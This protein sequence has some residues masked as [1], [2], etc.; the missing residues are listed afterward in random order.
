MGMGAGGLRR[1]MDGWSDDALGKAYDHTVVVRLAKYVRPYKWRVVIA[2]IGTILFSLT[3]YTQPYLIGQATDY[4]LA[5]NM[6]DLV[7]VSLGLVGLA[8]LAWVSYYGYM[9]TTAWMGH[10][11]LLTLREEMFSHLQKLSLSFYDRNEVG[12]VMSR[13]QNDVTSLQELLTSGFFTILADFLGLAVILFWLFKL[14]WVL[15]LGT[16]SVL[17]FL[18]IVLWI[19][20]ERAKKAF[21]RVRQAI[22]VVNSNLQENI[23]GVRV[24]Q[25]LNRESENQRRFDSVNADNLNA[26]VDAARLTAIVNPAVEISV[27]VAMAVVIILGGIRV[28]NGLTTVGVIVSFALYVQR[29]FDPVREL[30]MQYAQLQRAMAGGQRAFEVLD[31]QPEIED[32]PDALPIPPIKGDVTFEDVRFSYI[33]GIPVLRNINL[34]VSPGQNIALVGQTGSGKTTITAL[35]ARLYDVTSGSVRIDGIDVRDVQR[36]SINRQMGVV[37]QDPFLFSGTV[38]DNLRYGRPEATDEEIIEGSRAVG[39][40]EFI[41]QF[42]NGYDTVLVERGQN[43]SL[44][45][46]QLL[47]FARAIIANPRILV[48]DEATAKVDSTTEVSIQRA[49]K[50]L[51]KGRTSFV[52]AHRLSTIRGADRIIVLQSGKIVEDGTHEELVA[53]NG[54]YSSLY[55]M[56]Y[57]SEKAAG[58]GENGTIIAS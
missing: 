48:L 33:P 7:L 5:G 15:A 54:V 45:Q 29:F 43:I 14:D 3:S 53:R 21:I 16:I 19:W 36:I 8:L 4:A 13:V 35:I 40:H 20:Q 38:K 17:P 30:V 41:L 11:I 22:A 51:M 28:M 10:R 50:E 42:E 6:N 12:R 44:G 27:A 37:L 49:L 58:D 1:A 56:T 18:I 31:T 46:R 55:K 24:I 26:N 47:S 9:S 57:E 34:H 25:S 32:K 2:I 23:S 52:I 39:A